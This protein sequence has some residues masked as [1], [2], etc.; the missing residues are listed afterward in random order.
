M[1]EVTWPMT[2]FL[3]SKC[4]ASPRVIVNYEFLAIDST[5]ACACLRSKL[6]SGTGD[7]GTSFSSPPIIYPLGTT[8]EILE[9]K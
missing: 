7:Y 1:P 8:L 6:S 2:T 4:L 3:P 9:P 5:P